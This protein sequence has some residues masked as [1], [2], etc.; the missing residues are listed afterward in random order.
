LID[1]SSFQFSKFGSG[2]YSGAWQAGRQLVSPEWP[3]EVQQLAAAGGE[4]SGE[5]ERES[6]ANRAMIEYKLFPISKIKQTA[7]LVRLHCCALCALA[8]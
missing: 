1:A 3:H 5:R 6:S 8:T 4:E 2:F 7:Q